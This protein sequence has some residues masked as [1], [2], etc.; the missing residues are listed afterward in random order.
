MRLR[1][2][3][4][5]ALLV[6]P[7]TLP[8]QRIPVPRIGR[9]ATMPPAS[10]PPQAPGV[11]R[12][13]AYKRSRWSAEGYSLVSSIDL[14]G[15]G[16]STLHYTTMGTGTRADY[17]YADHL[18]ATVDMTTSLF[19]SPATVETAEIGTRYSPSSWDRP[20][21]PFADVRA[22]YMHVDDSFLVPAGT[23]DG[24]SGSAGA[25]VEADRYSHGLGGVAGAGL[26]YSLTRRL[27][28]TTELSAVRARLFISNLTNAGTLPTANRSWATSLRYTLGIR[29]NPVQ[30]LRTVQKVTP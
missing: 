25:M 17:R 1:T 28:L 27:T 2:F 14:P 7:A 26:E 29:F 19:G 12:A 21:R 22:I 23:L 3:A 15:M 11:T 18:S 9:R 10:L 30:T 5:I 20:L 24:G 4:T 16:G 13:L 6:L 8:A